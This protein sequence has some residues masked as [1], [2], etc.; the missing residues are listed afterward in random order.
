MW[1]V[2]WISAVGGLGFPQLC[3]CL[4]CGVGGV[5]HDSGVLKGK[6]IRLL[7]WGSCVVER[8]L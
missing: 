4:F 8:M 7:L 3:F 1:L 2:P 5:C 6:G